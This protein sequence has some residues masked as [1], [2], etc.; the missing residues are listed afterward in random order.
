METFPCYQNGDI[1]VFFCG[2]RLI[3]HSSKN[4]FQHGA[5]GEHVLLRME[6]F[7]HNGKYR[8]FPQT[9]GNI[10]LQSFPNRMDKRGCPKTMDTCSIFFLFKR[11]GAQ[12]STERGISSML[13]L[14][15]RK[16]I[17]NPKALSCQYFCKGNT[18]FC[19]WRGLHLR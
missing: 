8:F 10:N 11:F 19:E 5:Q 2:L 9:N 12:K 3:T 15:K 18:L 13:S 1:S 4:N 17:T 16:K 7:Q 6:F 14:L